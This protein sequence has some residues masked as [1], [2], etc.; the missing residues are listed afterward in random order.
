M[1]RTRAAAVLMLIT[2]LL[3]VAFYAN[4]IT[5]SVHMSVNEFVAV[6]AGRSTDAVQSNVILAIRFPR[7]IAAMILGGALALAG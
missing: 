3:A 5:G 6:L 7:I 2:L 1:S 4:M